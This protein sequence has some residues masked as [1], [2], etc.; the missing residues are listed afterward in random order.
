MAIPWKIFQIEPGNFYVNFNRTA[1]SYG[2]NQ[3][4]LPLKGRAWAQPQN[5]AKI[6]FDMALV[7]PVYVDNNVL[8][9]PV[10][11]SNSFA[12]F[13]INATK[14]KQTATAAIIVNNK[15]VLHTFN[16]MPESRLQ[17]PI[18]YSIKDNSGFRTFTY[19][20]KNK[21]LFQGE[22][23]TFNL[24]GTFTLHHPVQRNDRNVTGCFVLPFDNE[25]LKNS[26]VHYLVKTAKRKIVAKH[27]KYSEVL[28]LGKFA[29]GAYQAE[30]EL[31]N[32]TNQVLYKKVL[33]FNV[34]QAPI[35]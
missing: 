32:N 7:R 14:V 31:R 8:P 34:I 15:K 19:S 29:P 18:V 9:E 33:S 30:L 25:V 12:P 23:T 28:N 17:V 1:K 5:F 26:T 35:W 4:Y 6:N 16:I 21:V 27:V 13:F 20:V 22:N 11:G 10:M 3:S 2:E 24:S